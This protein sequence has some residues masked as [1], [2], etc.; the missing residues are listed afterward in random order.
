M[1]EN[2]NHKVR[3]VERMPKPSSRV[4]SRL[5]NVTVES[6]VRGNLGPPSVIIQAEP[7]TDWIKDRWQ[8]AS[9]MHGTNIKGRHWLLLDFGTE[10]IA[11][12]IVLDFEAAYADKYKIEA[13][14]LYP[15]KN[16]TET[17]TLFDGT[18][19]SQEKL[20][21]V[22]KSGQSP[23]VKFK[24]PLHVT[25]TIYPLKVQ[26][27]LRYLRLLILKSAMGWGVS[28]WQLDVYGVYKSETI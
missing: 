28:L 3:I 20:R 7:G 18:D 13:S 27:P 10:I 5:G 19:P 22:K 17:W 12:K 1:S 14:I 21:Q 24:T 26:K 8:A 25:H 2:Y 11:D 23:G 6:D 16:M 15:G 4:L 9:D